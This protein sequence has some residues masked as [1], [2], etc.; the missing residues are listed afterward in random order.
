MFINQSLFPFYRILWSISK[1]L[2]ELGKISS[3]YISSV[4]NKITIKNAQ[5]V[6]HAEDFKNYLQ[7]LSGC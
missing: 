7:L 1:S 3:N 5:L 2:H 6:T 4:R